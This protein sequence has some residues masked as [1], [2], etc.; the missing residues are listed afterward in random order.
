MTTFFC[1]LLGLTLLLWAGMLSTF[2]RPAAPHDFGPAIFAVLSAL[3]VWGLLAALLFL[4]AIKGEMPKWAKVLAW[5]LVPASLV[6]AVAAVDAN[7]G[8]SLSS[9]LQLLVPAVA[10]LMIAAYASWAYFPAFRAAISPLAAGSSAWGVVLVLAFLP[11]VIM[12]LES[13]AH[14]AGMAEATAQ[15]LAY[16]GAG[17]RAASLERLQRL[18]PDSH[19][20]D[21]L[22][23]TD[24]RY[25]VRE[26]ALA[27]ARA[28]THRQAD[29]DALLQGGAPGFMKD[30]PY[31]DLEPTPTIVAGHKKYLVD[32]VR[33]IQ[34]DDAGSVKYSWVSFEVDP[35]LPTI[36]WMA[37]RH[38]DCSAEM[39]ALEAAVRRYKGSPGK[40]ECLA[41][42]AKAQATGKK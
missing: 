28:L 35:Y 39:A 7:S 4:G 13:R 2:N 30:L 21:W 9:R 40:A 41:A 34:R 6:A 8:H 11:W 38:C 42:L 23:L 3:V 15:A 10:P 32:M 26:E 14:E 31:L 22:D 25:G 36:Q 12:T 20:W 18:T 5:V 19:L 16:E 29:A 33:G 27:G 17:N 1:V 24:P 37:E